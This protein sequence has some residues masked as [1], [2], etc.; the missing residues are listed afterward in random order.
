[1]TVG[2]NNPE[3][4]GIISH[5]SSALKRCKQ[6]IGQTWPTHH[7]PFTSDFGCIL[8]LPCS[9][10]LLKEES[11]HLH[12]CCSLIPTLSFFMA[13]ESE[14]HCFDFS[15]IPPSQVHLLKEFW[16]KASLTRA[17]QSRNL[18]WETPLGSGA[19]L[20]CNTHP[21]REEQNCYILQ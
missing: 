10:W 1:M 14:L 3:I 16:L 21:L 17:E 19:E 8:R 20:S 18:C 6:L 4:I 7:L 2:F 13:P 15:W 9:S 12:P 11:S 5:P